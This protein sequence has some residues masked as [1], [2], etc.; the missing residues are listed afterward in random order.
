MVHADGNYGDAGTGASS[1]GAV[2]KD[3]MH[4]FVTLE[5][6]GHNNGEND[7][8]TTVTTMSSIQEQVGWAAFDVGHSSLGGVVY[9]AG[10]TPVGSVTHVPYTIEFSGYFRTTPEFFANLG[11]YN[12]DDAALVRLVDT[13]ADDELGAV[14]TA[15]ATVQAEEEQCTGEQDGFVHG[16]GEEVDYFAVNKGIGATADRPRGGM[17]A[18]QI[19]GAG[20]VGTSGNHVPFAETGDLTLAWSWQSN[21]QTVSLRH[22]FLRPAIIMGTPST[23]GT[24]AVTVRIRNL[25][26]G[27]GCDG[28]CFDVRLQEPSCLDQT[29]AEETVHYLVVETGSWSGDEGNM[30]QAGVNEV[31]G[32]MRLTGQNFQIIQ[33]HGTGFPGA[34]DLPVVLTQVMSYYGA[35][36]VN[37]RQQQFDSTQ[38]FVALEEEGQFAGANGIGTQAH[39]NVEKVG[40]VAIEPSAGNFGTRNFEAGHTPEAVTHDDYVITFTQSFD[41][42]PRFFA[43]MATYYGTD[44]SQVRHSGVDTT[45]AT[46]KVEE[47]NCSDAEQ[48]HVPEIVDWIALETREGIMMGRS[49]LPL[50]CEGIQDA[51]KAQL[52]GGATFDPSSQAAITG[53]CMG[54]NGIDPTPAQNGAACTAAGGTWT[55]VT[56]AAAESSGGTFGTGFINFQGTVGETATW[57][58]HRC[59]Q[60]HYTIAIGYSLYS[61]DRPM[62]VTVNGVVV[63]GFLAM[64]ETGSWSTYREVRVAAMM[65]AGQNEVV[66]STIGFSGPNVD[67]IAL[68]PIGSNA[69]GD[70]ATIGQAGIVET[71]DYRDTTGGN[72]VDEQW[73]TVELAE[74]MID[75]VVF[76]GITTARGTQPVIP[77]LKGIH[78]SNPLGDYTDAANLATDD[79][80][81]GHCFDMRLQEPSCFDDLHLAE[82]IHYLVLEA[83]TWYTDQGKMF[84]VGRL[85]SSGANGATIDVGAQRNSGLAG[86]WTQVTYHT[87]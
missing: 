86:G 51:T 74:A 38:F 34:A 7:F 59:I 13:N 82:E 28:W 32:D 26:H 61:G 27:Q 39:T 1:A 85:Q 81:N 87:P 58:F 2:R 49:N 18:S 75:P 43:R 62:S 4:F 40:W 30:L 83:G 35:N 84:Q 6:E 24:E 25:R 17:V 33:F 12:G 31:E 65:N 52:T 23:A 48:N 29:H 64:P 56:G 42:A 80:C 69:A 10:K 66:L 3:T 22:Y 47:E 11:S 72:T 44:S 5:T 54:A 53:T 20:E 73:L 77:R 15:G 63:D 78:Y 46:V 71:I 60:G 79:A 41:T 19:I 76:I 37:T 9:E 68:V 8:H 67:Y 14:T 21:W 55:G 16:M 45:Q 50:G 57:T 70:T 36:F